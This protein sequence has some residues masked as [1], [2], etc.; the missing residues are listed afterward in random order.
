[1]EIL[2]PRWLNDHEM[3]YWQITSRAVGRNVDADQTVDRE[4]EQMRAFGVSKITMY[5][6]TA[7]RNGFRSDSVSQYSIVEAPLLCGL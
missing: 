5:H 7:G 4:R 1:M 3:T 2:A 6:S